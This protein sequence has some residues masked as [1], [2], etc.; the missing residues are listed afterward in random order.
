VADYCVALIE[1]ARGI[2]ELLRVADVQ[3]MMGM[4]EETR[5]LLRPQPPT[6][7]QDK[8]VVRHVSNEITA[9]KRNMAFG[10]MNSSDFAF[11][12]ADPPINHRLAYIKRNIIRLAFSKCKSDQRRIEKEFAA[13]G[14]ERYLVVMSELFRQ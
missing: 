2:A 14:H 8:K 6:Q 3:E 7:C 9:S 13:A 11:N 4:F 10:R 1:E 5:Y 12:E